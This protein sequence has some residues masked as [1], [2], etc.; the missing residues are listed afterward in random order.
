MSEQ[1]IIKTED[2]WKKELTP[3]EYHVMREKGTEAPFAGKYWD[4]HEQG[5]YRCRACGNELFY[6][7]QNSIRV[8]AGRVFMRRLLIQM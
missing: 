6:R 8:R 1:K 7:T 3:E 2:E 5:M 4:N